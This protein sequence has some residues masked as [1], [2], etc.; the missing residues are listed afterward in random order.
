MWPMCETAP[1]A[2]PAEG[3]AES[4]PE[5]GGTGAAAVA[6]PTTPPAGHAADSPANRRPRWE[7][8]GGRREK[9]PSPSGGNVRPS[10]WP[11]GLPNR[12]RCRSGGF[13]GGIEGGRQHPSPARGYTG[14]SPPFVNGVE[15]GVATPPRGCGETRRRFAKRPGGRLASPRTGG[16]EK[17][18]GATVGPLPELA[19]E[20]LWETSQKGYGRQASIPPGATLRGSPSEA[21]GG[22]C[23]L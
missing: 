4:V 21:G 3:R 22:P 7:G 13:P 5:A 16:R 18:L 12:E 6:T 1:E 15:G 10:G 8:I 20:G 23:P 2:T 11:G 9:I 19:P 14:D 17:A